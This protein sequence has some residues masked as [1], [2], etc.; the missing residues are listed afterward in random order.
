MTDETKELL[1]KCKEAGYKAVTVLVRD[2]RV[3][4][5]VAF[6]Q[7]FWFGDLPAQK[8]R[9]ALPIRVICAE[10]ERLGKIPNCPKPDNWP[11]LWGIVRDCGLTAGINGGLGNGDAININ[12]ALAGTLT[13][14]CYEL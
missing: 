2:K 5:S 10:P 3:P 8:N 1:S 6:K 13:E 14:G 11:L 4:A 7:G 9:P 12:P